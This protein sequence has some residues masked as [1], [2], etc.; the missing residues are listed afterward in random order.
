MKITSFYYLAYPDSS[1]LDASVAESEVYFEVSETEGSTDS[2]RFH[3][4]DS[5]LHRWFCSPTTCS[6]PSFLLVR[7]SL[8]NALKIL[9]L[10][11]H[12]NLS[13]Q[14]LMKLLNGSNREPLRRENRCQKGKPMSGSGKIGVTG[15]IGPGNGTQ[16]NSKTSRV[17][18]SL[19]L[20]IESWSSEALSWTETGLVSSAYFL[21]NTFEADGTYSIAPGGYDQSTLATYSGAVTFR[22]LFRA[23]PARVAD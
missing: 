11:S 6:C 5:C 8:S 14:G 22:R 15:K 13:Y 23:A 9:L 4:L 17:P 16:R 19:P 21:S 20:L 18:V 3:I 10:R 2:F 7:W 12:W 1:P